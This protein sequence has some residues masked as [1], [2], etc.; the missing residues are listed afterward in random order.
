MI[1]N[2]EAFIKTIRDEIVTFVELESKT[3]VDRNIY[4]KLQ[5]EKLE[6]KK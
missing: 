2:E 4:E 3:T 1:A 5:N 6:D